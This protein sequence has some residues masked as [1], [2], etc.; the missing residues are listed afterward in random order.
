MEPQPFCIKCVLARA[1]AFGLWLAAIAW[2]SLTPQPPQIDYPLLSWDKLQHA[3]AYALLAFLGG[4]LAALLARR[5]LVG[6]LLA[7][8]FCALI[9]VSFEV[10]Q[11][12]MNIG[13]VLEVGDMAANAL[14][15]LAVFAG[16]WIWARL[17][18]RAW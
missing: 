8:A 6:W 13:R 2:L 7:A 16:A 4:R 17:Q 9:G 10:A 15:A 11:A 12:Q 3:S 18:G 5:R 1:A 14:G